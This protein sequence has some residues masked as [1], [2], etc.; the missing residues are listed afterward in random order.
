MLVP[1]VRGARWDVGESAI[2]V[3]DSALSLLAEGDVAAEGIAD[4]YFLLLHYTLGSVQ[5]ED[6]A[7][8]NARFRDTAEQHATSLIDET[9]LAG[10]ASLLEHGPATDE[11]DFERRFTPASR[12]SSAA[13]NKRRPARPDRTPQAGVSDSAPARLRSCCSAVQLPRRL[14]DSPHP[15]PSRAALPESKVPHGHD[16]TLRKGRTALVASI[17]W[18]QT[19]YRFAKGTRMELLSGRT[20]IVTG[21]S[22]GIGRAA[23]LAFA[24]EG[25]N[26]VIGDTDT[27]RGPKVA[28]EVE[29]EGVRALF[30]ATDVS[31]PDDCERLVDRTLETF[32]RLDAAFNNAGIEGVPALTADCTIENW[33]RTL[34]VNLTG[35]WLCMRAEIPAMLRNGGG[36]IVNTASVAGLVG[37]PNIPAYTASKHGI[38]G[39]TKTAAL[40]YAQTGIRVNAVCPGVID[41][42]MIDRFTAGDAEARAALL[43]R[44][45]RTSRGAR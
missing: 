22:A 27:D 38:I 29:H 26:V 13:S 18:A 10:Y 40:E 20:V 35:V 42:E 44:T 32:G 24:R 25:A 9:P 23:A 19:G 3:A 21:G 7:R 17:W 39:L 31:K 36:A 28:A 34:A 15:Q 5:A 16:E 33:Q 14:V 37:F 45:G 30:V 12:S 8:Y 43:P 4:A 1:V 41:T 2:R 6:H 11:G